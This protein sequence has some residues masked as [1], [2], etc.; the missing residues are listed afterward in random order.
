MRER[1]FTVATGLVLIALIVFFAVRHTPTANRVKNTLLRETSLIYRAYGK[2]KVLRAESPHDIVP[3]HCEKVQRVTYSKVPDLSGLPPEERKRKFIDLILPS[4]LIANEEVR[5]IRKSLL[6]ITL[7]FQK[8]I[9]LTGREREFLSSI[10]QRCR[11]K[12]PEEVLVKA[13]PVPPSLVIAQS[14]VETGW[15]T[16][17]FF[18]EGNNLFGMWTFREKGSVIKAK[19]SEVSLRVYPTILDS[20]R[21]YLYTLNVGWAFEGFRSQRL[22]SLNPL[23]LSNFMDFYSIERDEYVR[24]IKRIIRENNLTRFDSCTLSDNFTR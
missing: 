7:K 22:R 3:V 15:G 4:I 21:G 24:K 23:H 9:P 13:F 11:A 8:G 20:V 10:L 19:G 16:S 5:Y 14:A 2:V 12:S 17:R 6:G 18:V 1:V